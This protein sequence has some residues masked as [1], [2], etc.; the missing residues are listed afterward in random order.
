MRGV[1]KQ[2]LSND[3]SVAQENFDPVHVNCVLYGV[4][5]RTCAMGGRLARRFSDWY[6]VDFTPFF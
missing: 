4:V 1:L 2:F 6:L 5:E 3:S